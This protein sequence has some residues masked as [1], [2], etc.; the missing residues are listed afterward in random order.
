MHSCIFRFKISVICVRQKT[1]WAWSLRSSLSS[2]P[3]DSVSVSVIMV[4]TLAFEVMGHIQRYGNLREKVGLCQKF[5]S[6]KHQ[7][8]L[9]LLF[10]LWD[11]LSVFVFSFF[12]PTLFK[13]MIF[14]HC[15]SFQIRHV[16][17]FLLFFFFFYVTFLRTVVWV[18][19]KTAFKMYY[20]LHNSERKDFLLHC[21][22]S[23][24][25]GFNLLL[26]HKLSIW[27]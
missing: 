11:F 16:R 10:C 13:W 25:S 7:L 24:K 1:N 23:R 21:P 14:N 26:W 20:V 19:G 3:G 4:K 5:K 27:D 9:K 6:F 2:S 17:C 8:I 18:W 15:F 22:W 12:Q